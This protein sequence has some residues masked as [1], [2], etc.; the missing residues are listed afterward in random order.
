MQ[1]ERF[2][3]CWI[4]LREDQVKLVKER[5][6][7]CEDDIE[8]FYQPSFKLGGDCS[9]SLFVPGRVE[10]FGAGHNRQTS[11]AAAPTS[12]FF[13]IM[14]FVSLKGTLDTVHIRSIECNLTQAF[15]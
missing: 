3:L 11:L 9:L 15:I 2:F 1:G 14:L 12:L 10:C 13:H 5:F 6:E 8:R 7:R 4:N